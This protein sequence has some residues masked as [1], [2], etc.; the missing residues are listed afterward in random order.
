MLKGGTPNMAKWLLVVETNCVDA[1]RE[2]EFNEWYDKIHLHDVLRTPGFIR[3]T[4]YESTSP[5][6][7]KAKFLAT[8][9]IETEDIGET[10]KANR[11][12]MSR[13]RAE[14]RYSELLK[15]VSSTVYRQIGGLFK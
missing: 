10:M 4:R 5:S 9:E 14:G 7:G 13:R 11:D 1:A 12:N 3:A 15:V 8:Y 2:V 6:E